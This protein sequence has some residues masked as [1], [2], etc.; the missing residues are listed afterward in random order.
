M[1]FKVKTIHDEFVPVEVVEAFPILEMPDPL[2]LG[3]LLGLMYRNPIDRLTLT[4]PGTGEFDFPCYLK[5]D[6]CCWPSEM[7][8]CTVEV[9]NWLMDQRADDTRH[10]WRK[11]G[12]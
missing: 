1:K 11:V 12:F 9:L 3:S 7:F 10:D 5:I 2:T 6:F 8:F 4:R